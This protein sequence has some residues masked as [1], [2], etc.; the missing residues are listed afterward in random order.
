MIRVIGEIHGGGPTL[1][2]FLFY[3]I[4]SDGSADQLISRHAAKVIETR[5]SG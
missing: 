4:A 5:I 1:P 3:A 2:D